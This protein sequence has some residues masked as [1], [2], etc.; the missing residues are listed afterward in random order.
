MKAFRSLRRLLPAI[1]ALLLGACVTI[2]VYFPAAAAEKAAEEFVGK[3]IGPDPAP[4]EQ[5]PEPKPKPVS[6]LGF[7]ISDAVAADQPDLNLSTPAIKNLEGRMAERFKAALA[8]HFDSGA[9]GFTRDG[10]VELRDAAAVPLAD[11]A[12][13]KQAVAEDNRDR[14]AVY[15]EIALANGHAE[16]EADIRA[17]FAKQWV[18]AAH[19]GWWYQDTSGQWRRK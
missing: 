14:D 8:P 10:H 13:V 6:L 3:V 19:A 16:W 15:R 18:A 12:G 5:A 17:T 1:A 4:R 7:F 11:R 9:L 2:N